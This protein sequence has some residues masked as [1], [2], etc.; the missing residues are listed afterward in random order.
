MSIFHAETN[1]PPRVPGLW[2][3]IKTG[4]NFKFPSWEG[5]ENIQLNLIEHSFIN[6]FLI[7]CISAFYIQTL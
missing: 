2:L 6:I 5:S 3:D 4:K 1:T 7:D